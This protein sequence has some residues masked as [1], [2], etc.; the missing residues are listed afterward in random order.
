MRNELSHDVDL[1]ID[2]MGMVLYSDGAVI[3]IAEG[4]NYF[5]KEFSTPEQ[6]AEHLKKGDIIGFN[7]GSAGSYGVKFRSGYPNEQ[8]EQDFPISIR[9]AL[10]VKGGA[11]SIIDLFWLMEWSKEC[12]SEQQLNLEDGIYHVTVSTAKP[13]SGIWGDNQEVY[14]YLNKLDEMPTL[15]WAGIPQLFT[16]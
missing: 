14:I 12:P 15:T 6:V 11:L 9:L 13:M 10:Q 1:M 5:Q 8:M 2:G 3:H 16:E 4:E 7:T